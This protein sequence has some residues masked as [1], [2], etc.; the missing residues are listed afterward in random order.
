[1]AIYVRAFAL[2]VLLCVISAMPVEEQ[3][4]EAQVDLVAV[5]NDP[6]SEIATAVNDDLTRTKR[7]CELT[8][9]NAL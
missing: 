1:M 2:V 5:E 8:I 7:Q 9:E 3:K 6:Q 4:E